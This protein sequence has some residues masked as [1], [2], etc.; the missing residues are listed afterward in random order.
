MIYKERET[1]MAEIEASGNYGNDSNWKDL[2]VD[3]EHEGAFLSLEEN[4]EVEMEMEMEMETE[5]PLKDGIEQRS[6][7]RKWGFLVNVEKK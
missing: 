1:K 6:P 2:F 5:E 4:W 3:A 7:R